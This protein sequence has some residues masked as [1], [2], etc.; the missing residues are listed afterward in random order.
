MHFIVISPSCSKKKGKHKLRIPDENKGE[1]GSHVQI[2]NL[3]RFF[4]ANA[5]L[6]F[7]FYFSLLLLEK[8]MVKWKK[9]ISIFAYKHF[10]FWKFQWKR[11]SPASNC[12]ACKLVLTSQIEIR[13]GH[14]F[15]S[16][17]LYLNL[18]WFGPN[19]HSSN[20]QWAFTNLVRHGHGHELHLNTL[21]F[22]EHGLFLHLNL[23]GFLVHLVLPVP[24]VRLRCMGAFP[25]PLV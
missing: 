7:L 20:T 15:Y 14:I 24:F 16:K 23:L 9:C 17:A 21:G 11:R 1:R 12:R 25:I 13:L 10:F 18:I 2:Q 6:F 22:H 8:Y 5:S 19:G 4:N 3:A